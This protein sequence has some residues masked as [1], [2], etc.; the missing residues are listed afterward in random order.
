MSHPRSTF[1]QRLLIF[2]ACGL[3]LTVIIPIVWRAREITTL[4]NDIL[5]RV[6]NLEWCYMEPHKY[7]IPEGTSFVLIIYP[8][9]PDPD[10]LLRELA[11]DLKQLRRV[12]IYAGSTRL[13]DRGLGELHLVAPLCELFVDET[14]VSSLAIQQLKVSVP[15]CKVVHTTRA[16]YNTK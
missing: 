6:N 1:R 9:C 2:L 11:P 12:D 5:T 7:G 13:T 15:G 4:E 8:D 16:W 10:S 3:I 14:G